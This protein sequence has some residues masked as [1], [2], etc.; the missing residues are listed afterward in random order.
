MKNSKVRNLSMVGLSICA[1]VAAGVGLNACSSSKS[2]FMVWGPAEHTELYTTLCAE[3]VKNNPDFPCNFAYGSSGDAGAFAA[4]S[5]DPTSGADVFTFPNDQLNN[6]NRLGV[7][8]PVNGDNLTWAKKKNDATSVEA[9]KIGDTY[10]AYPVQGDNGYY[11]YYRK[12]I[13]KDTSI[14]DSTTKTLKSDYTFRDMYK[15]LDE[16]N[17]TNDKVTWAIGDSWYVSG[18]FFATGSDYNVEYDEK[19]N[20]KSVTCTFGYDKSYAADAKGAICE[21]GMK[22]VTA[23]MN[24]ITD[25]VDGKTIYDYNL[26]PHYMY[27]DGSAQSL[28]DHITTYCPIKAEIKTPLVACVCGTWKAKELRGFWGDEL[29]ATYLPMIESTDGMYRMKNFRG[30]KLMGVNP[31]SA[32]NSKS[33]ENLAWSHKV[34]QFLSDKES[35]IA[36]YNATGAGPSNLEALADTTIKNDV[37]LSAL[38][39]QYNLVCNY[40]TGATKAGV[41]VSGKPVGNGYGYRVQDSVPSNYW[42]PIQNFGAA[43][44]NHFDKRNDQ[45]FNTEGNTRRQLKQL[46]ADVESAAQ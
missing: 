23:L 2:T 6:L 7:V 17:L 15:A 33:K 36:R 21:N 29:G 5:T 46:Q 45:S 38:N 12:D 37:V 27:S 34:A 9:G 14:W 18:A 44:Y 10:K 26:N 19:G 30:Y 22:A 35:Q 28:N 4:M 40:P 43:I 13:F 32:F 1:M 41:D 42:T 39:A 11:M 24:T 31:L 8:A 3:F 25:K 20:Q 16:K